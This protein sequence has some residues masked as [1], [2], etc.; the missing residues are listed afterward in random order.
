MIIAATGLVGCSGT[1]MQSSD[2]PSIGMSE[3]GGGSLGGMPIELQTAPDGMVSEEFR[4]ATDVSSSDR[5]VIVT[6]S[7]LITVDSPADAADDTARIVESAGGH[8][9]ARTE[10]APRNGFAGRAD[11]TVRIPADRLDATLEQIGELGKVEERNTQ[12]VDVTQVTEDL[13]ARITALQA[14]VDRLLGLM[15]QA[16]TTADLIAIESALSE[17]QAN[18]ESL[19]A[20]RASL[21]DQVDY[22]TVSIQLVSEAEAPVDEPDTF[23]SGLIAGWQALVGFFSFL[24][25][26]LGVLLPWI[27]LAIIA[28]VILLLVRRRRRRSVAAATAGADNGRSIAPK[29]GPEAKDDSAAE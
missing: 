27:P 26:A 5:Q 2:A 28:V 6:G 25:I 17:R 9:D 10:T 7:A 23:F 14:S 21:A 19:Q 22:S 16:T 15:S 4:S 8:V 29:A 12:S 11:L 20:Q 1:S 18:L 24:L 3:S 13:D